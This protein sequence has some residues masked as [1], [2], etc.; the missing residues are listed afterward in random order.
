MEQGSKKK[1][2]NRKNKSRIVKWSA[3]PCPEI[4]FID[5]KTW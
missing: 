1:E 4:R 5:K 2:Y 3:T